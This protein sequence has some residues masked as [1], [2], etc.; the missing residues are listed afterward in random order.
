MK[1]AFL[2]ILPI[3]ASPLL[4]QVV[5]P[6][7]KY[8]IHYREARELDDDVDFVRTSDKEVIYRTFSNGVGRP[9]FLETAWSP[10]STFL[11]VIVHGTQTTYSVE[12][13]RFDSAAVTQMT[14]P[15]YRLN[16]LG[17][18]ELVEGGRYSFARGL[19]WKG[20]TLSFTSEGNLT[21]GASNPQDQPDDWYHYQISLKLGNQGVHLTKVID[22]KRI[23]KNKP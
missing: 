19:S 1:A 21:K 15:D 13:Y 18:H 23:R 3:F 2:L 8:A 20:P 22:L 9:K 5:S 11:A 12:I 16:L 17:R 6:N 4:S 14:L 7:G 10:D